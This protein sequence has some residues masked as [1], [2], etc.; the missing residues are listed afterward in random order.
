VLA[1]LAGLLMVAGK[2]EEAI[3][4][5]REALA[6][7]DELGLGDMRAYALNHLGSARLVGGD[8]NGLADLEQAV[9]AALEANS[10]ECVLAYIN[11]ASFVVEL[12]DL[13][14][15]FKLQADGRRAA[16][17]FGLAGWVRHL[18][19]ERV[20]EHYWLG[21]WDAAV[22]GADEFI[23]ESEAATSHYMDSACRW[24]R[25]RIRLARADLRGALE[26]ADQMLS[27][28]RAME[29]PQMLYAALAFR[30]RMFV[31]AGDMDQA[32]AYASDLLVRLADQGGGLIGVDWPGD[33]AVVLQALGRG[34]ELAEFASGAAPTPWLQAAIA[35]A[36]DEFEQA[37]DVYAELGS[38]PDE[39]FARLRAAKQLVAGGRQ[40]E[41]S[42]QL[43]RALVFFR[44]VEAS[45][46][47]REAEALLAASA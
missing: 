19:A 21:Q 41:A 14:R 35:F 40:I 12:G 24:I 23:A 38:L 18:Q 17:R 37:T 20:F 46:Y 2:A 7:A 25:G 3:P 45:A 13:A 42:K 31:A 36:G 4:I 33:L 32:A 15:A 6:V 34:S 27:S 39:A 16:E 28:V 29:D 11:L 22:R 9:A 47:L 43:E 1:E 10:P 5:G 8:R 30:A 26:D 44:E